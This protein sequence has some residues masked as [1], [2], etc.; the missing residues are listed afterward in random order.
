MQTTIY[1]LL[2]SI[3]VLQID[4]GESMEAQSSKPS[5]PNIPKCVLLVSL[6]ACTHLLALRG[7]NA[8]VLSVSRHMAVIHLLFSCSPFAAHSSRSLVKIVQNSTVHNKDRRFAMCGFKSYHE[9]VKNFK[10]S[11]FK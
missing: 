9:V 2:F 5:H 8:S 11:V 3:F 6:G 4:S 10:V 7:I 1:L